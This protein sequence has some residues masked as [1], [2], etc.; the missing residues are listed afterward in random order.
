MAVGVAFKHEGKEKVVRTNSEIILSAGT[1]GTTKLLLLS[2]VGPRKHL[3]DLKVRQGYV[4][5]VEPP[6]YVTTD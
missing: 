2:G 4:V 1:I 6:H 5:H 3:Q